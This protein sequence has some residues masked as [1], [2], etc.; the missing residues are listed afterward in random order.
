MVHMVFQEGQ[1]MMVPLDTQGLKDHLALKV[2]LQQSKIA[3][4]VLHIVTS[5]ATEA[6]LVHKVTP[7]SR[8]NQAG[9]V[10]LGILVNAFLVQLGHLEAMVDQVMMEQ[11]VDLVNQ[12]N[13]EDPETLLLL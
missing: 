6:V 8:V 13:Q 1:E 3:P 10:L 5:K 7:G 2:M 12:V 11:M 9:Q 4:S